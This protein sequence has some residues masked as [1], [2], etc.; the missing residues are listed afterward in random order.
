MNANYTCMSPG[1]SFSR[2][3]NGRGQSKAG[4]AGGGGATLRKT[5]PAWP[6]PTLFP[7]SFPPVAAKH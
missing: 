2:I 4:Q 6:S 7:R 3:M 5:L 1:G